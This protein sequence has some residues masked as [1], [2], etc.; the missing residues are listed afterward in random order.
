M[1]VEDVPVQFDEQTIRIAF[2]AWL[3]GAVG[4]KTK[5][6]G[7]NE[8]LIG[9]LIAILMGRRM[10]N[11]AQNRPV[12]TTDLV[13][14]FAAEIKDQ[15]GPIEYAALANYDIPMLDAAY[16]QILSEAKKS[17]V[18]L[19]GL[20]LALNSIAVVRQYAKRFMK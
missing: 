2:T 7:L 10:V 14:Q 19:N 4:V 5:S 13:R 15:I 20:A 1:R 9:Q 16:A 6:E 3:M 8:D 17:G 18:D 11:E 12:A